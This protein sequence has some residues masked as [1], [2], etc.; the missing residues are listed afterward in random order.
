[1]SADVTEASASSPT[2][3]RRSSSSAAGVL[4][5][6]DVEAKGDKLVIHKDA[7][8]AKISWKMNSASSNI[9]DPDLLGKHV[10]TPPVKKLDLKFPQTGLIITARNMKGVTYKDVCDAIHK[11]MKKRADD[12]L[13]KPYLAGLYYDDEDASPTTLR[14]ALTEHGAPVGKKSKKKGGDDA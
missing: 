6:A 11:Q 9:S 7:A 4:S 5:A 1:M 2:K 8:G 13:D 14:L 12:E 10:T 3:H